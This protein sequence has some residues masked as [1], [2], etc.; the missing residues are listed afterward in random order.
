MQHR[1]PFVF[2][3]FAV[4]CIALT[5]LTVASL[6]SCA[7]QTDDGH[8]NRQSMSQAVSTAIAAREALTPAARTYATAQAKSNLAEAALEDAITKSERL[9]T[10]FERGRILCGVHPDRVG[11]S[12]RDEDGVWSGFFVDMCKAVATAVFGNPEWV[13]F[14]EIAEGDEG[15]TLIAGDVDIL[16]TGINWTMQYESQWGN[17]TLPIYF[18]GQSVMVKRDSD[19]LTLSDITGETVCTVEDDESERALLDWAS[20]DRIEV[21]T[22]QF[23]NLT[24]AISAYE[25]GFCSALTETGPELSAIRQLLESPFDHRL[26]PGY[27]DERE[28]VL[29]VPTGNDAWFDV[30]KFVVTGLIH[31]EMLGV[32]SESIGDSATSQDIAVRRIGGYEGDFGQDALYLSPRVLQSVVGAVGNY[33]EIYERHF[34]PDALDVERGRNRLVNDGGSIWAPPIR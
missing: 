15:D 9:S 22:M 3:T 32:T 11:L 7:A 2:T 28:A 31:A 20:T 23:S 19:V 17:A 8:A 24:D 33:G 30:V 16:A 1:H 18:G 26:L 5:A 10:V 6:I 27:F 34:G 25:L 14:I 29:A 4:A 13:Q 12:I 21:G